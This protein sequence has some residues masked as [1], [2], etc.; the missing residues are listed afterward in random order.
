MDTDIAKLAIKIDSQQA[1]IAALELDRLGKAGSRAEKSSSNLERQWSSLTSTGRHLAQIMTAIGSTAVVV[2]LTKISAASIKAASDLNE[3]SSKFRVVFKGQEA[4]AEQWARTL[5]DS[6]AMS[7]RESKQYLS[8]VQDLLVPM[9]M[10]SDAAGKMSFKITSLAADLGSFDNLPTAQVMDDIQSAL[11]GNYETMK[12]YGVVLNATNVQQ[13]A[14]AMGLAKT[15]N[16]LTAADKAQAA[17]KLIV[18]GSKAAIGDMARTSGGY[19]NQLKEMHAR[20]EDMKAAFGQ[21]LLP[22]MT[23]LLKQFN[24]WYKANDKVINQDLKGWAE[25]AVS[26]IS[27]LA[28]AVNSLATGYHAFL[29][30]LDEVQDYLISVGMGYEPLTSNAQAAAVLQVQLVKL[31]KELH[32]LGDT[33]GIWATISGKEDK[34]TEIQTRIM[35]IKRRLQELRAAAANDRRFQDGLEQDKKAAKEL[36]NAVKHIAGVYHKVGSAAEKSAKDAC[37]AGKKQRKCAKYTHQQLQEWA[38]QGKLIGKDMWL[39]YAEGAE[40]AS[41]RAEKAIKD[42]NDAITADLEDMMKKNDDLWGFEAKQVSQVQQ[43]MVNDL[44]RIFDTYINDIL[45]GQIHSI[46]DLFSGL[47]DSILKMFMRTL[48]QMAANS[49][50]EAIFGKGSSGGPTLSSLGGI[51]SSISSA[52]GGPSIGSLA[53]SAASSLG[54]VG[55]ATTIAPYAA[56]GTYATLGGGVSAAGGTGAV[57]GM[58]TFGL[59]QEGSIAGSTAGASAGASSST[60]AGSGISGAGMATAGAYAAIIAIGGKI[61]SGIIHAKDHSLPHNAL[62][63][64]SPL[65]GHGYGDENILGKISDDHSLLSSA[66]NK[67]YDN[68]IDGAK[69][70]SKEWAS[71]IQTLTDDLSKHFD[72][73]GVDRFLE[74]MG[75]IKVSSS[76]A[77]KAIDLAN[78]AVEGSPAAMDKLTKALMDMGMNSE[79][80]AAATAA[81]MKAEVQRGH[82]VNETLGSWRRSIDQLSSTHLDLNAKATLDVEVRGAAKDHASVSS[83][84]AS[85]SSTWNHGFGSEGDGEGGYHNDGNH[86]QWWHPHASGGIFERPVAIGSHLFGEA[87]PEILAPL[88]GGAGAFAEM[89]REI[90]MLVSKVGGGSQPITI[91]LQNNVAGRKVEEVIIPVIDKHIDNR[92]RAGVSGRVA[93]AVG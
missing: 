60:A 67:M 64:L 37:E 47:F 23:D 74:A 35:Q 80:A 1:R 34:A 9:G 65:A 16:E 22:V 58:A 31:T 21:G 39:S 55:G 42:R 56:G 24:D 92:E 66:I 46:G 61:I 53:S 28:S 26:G 86:W 8:S 81:L 62:N 25:G 3:V 63:M 91:V 38:I 10:A 27:A 76:D 7:T 51:A 12:K 82:V 11:V 79:A 29:D 89:A 19:A 48:S 50:V 93:Y 49:L 90:K 84:I 6:Y 83:S 70:V 41:K 88:P 30:W 18:E 5:V 77:A 36:E 15:K 54:I 78:Q 68:M 2:G 20:I 57:G 85:H 13:K 73:P 45:D 43:D 72:I 87:G 17:Y 40:D 59:P 4:Q 52:L 69:H 33:D 71:A 32:D 75:G 14:L 44:G